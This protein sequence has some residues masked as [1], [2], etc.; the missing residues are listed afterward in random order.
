MELA[1]T[2]RAHL[3][4][5]CSGEAQASE[6]TSLARRMPGLSITAVDLRPDYAHP[7]LADFATTANKEA[8]PEHLGD[9]SLK[10]NL[11]LLVAE[12]AGWRSLM[13]L[14][15]DIA[16]IS[17]RFVRRAA[18]GLDSLAAVGLFARNY[19]DNSVVCHANRL[20]GGR[21]GVFIS[22]SALVVDPRRINGF[23]PQIYN[24]DWLFL[25]DALVDRV[26][27]FAGR[28]RQL[29]YDPFI[30]PQRAAGEEFGE[31]LAEGLMSLLHAGYTDPLA[32]GAGFWTE[33]LR[34]RG[35]FIAST[36]ER[37]RRIPDPDIEVVLLALKTAETARANISAEHLAEYVRDW[38]SDLAR[39]AEIRSPLRTCSS[40]DE[41]LRR[42][43]LAPC[44]VAAV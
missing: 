3:V 12:S 21:Q 28:V 20:G 5:F 6:V 4:V 34:T 8:A 11:A 2:M 23:F 41:G 36:A 33:F 1:T 10:R 31:V 19:P 40:L 16:D 13:F 27:G 44:R 18:A 29:R 14:D 42:L 39:W 22:G 9:L 25:F 24:E 30:K 17:P 43:Q 37:I 35:E 32:A 15:D 38:R 26:V 7:G